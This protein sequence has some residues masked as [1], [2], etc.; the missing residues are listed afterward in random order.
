[1]YPGQAFSGSAAS[2]YAL[3]F[4]SQTTDPEARSKVAE[5]T[6]SLGAVT[7]IANTNT[8]ATTTILLPLL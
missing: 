6:Q 8:I 4:R 5:A 2:K 1:M 3:A 7:V